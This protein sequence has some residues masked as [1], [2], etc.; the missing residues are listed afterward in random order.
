V[1]CLTESR[2]RGGKPSKK[3]KQQFRIQDQQK[4]HIK[5]AQ[6]NKKVLGRDLSKKIN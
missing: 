1:I 5:D 2:Y 4:A 6:R 3:S